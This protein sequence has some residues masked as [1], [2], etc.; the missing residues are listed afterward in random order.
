MNKVQHGRPSTKEGEGVL[1]GH[2]EG[3]DELNEILWRTRGPGLCSPEDFE[4]KRQR[5]EEEE[6]RNTAPRRG[7]S[8]GRST[9]ED[10]VPERERKTIRGP[11]PLGENKKRCRPQRTRRLRA[12][13]PPKDSSPL[14]PSLNHP[15][16]YTQ[17]TS[18][19]TQRPGILHAE[20]SSGHNNQ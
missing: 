20:G 16:N 14:P 11:K 15:P 1:A 13:R 8:W 2:E 19:S 3:S 10:P 7:A 12:S 5:I 17:C 18:T 9:T 4:Y 6:E